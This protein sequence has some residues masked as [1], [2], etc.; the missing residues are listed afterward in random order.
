MT[1]TWNEIKNHQVVNRW[2]NGMGKENE[3]GERGQ[4]VRGYFAKGVRTMGP[5]KEEL[6]AE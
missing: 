3:V 4:E 2:N 1:G 5:T 6:T